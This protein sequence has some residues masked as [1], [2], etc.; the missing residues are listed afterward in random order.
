MQAVSAVLNGKYIMEGE[1]FETVEVDFGRSAANNI[2]QASGKNG[3]NRTV[4]PSIRHLIS[5]CTAT[6]HPD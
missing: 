4:I 1:Q 3:Q 6:R 5:I 2:T